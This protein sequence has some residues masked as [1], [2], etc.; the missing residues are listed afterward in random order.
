MK[1]VEFKKKYNKETVY[2]ISYAKLPENTS[3]KAV[4]N[5]V[6]L[7][8]VI[9]YV[10]GVIEDNS[11]TL[12]TDE[13]KDFLKDIIKGYNLYEN[14]IDPLIEEVRNR[15]HGSSQKSICVILKDNHNKFLKW[16]EE[17]NI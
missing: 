14:G 10:T 15:F 3:A 1:H 6:G 13:A 16:K 12:L 2:V 7:G 17:N 8:L 11:C 4:H 5:M 9:N